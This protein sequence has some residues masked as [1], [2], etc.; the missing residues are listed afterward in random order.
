MI[1]MDLAVAMVEAEQAL[2]TEGNKIFKSVTVEKVT[3]GENGVKVASKVTETTLEDV[4][5]FSSQLWEPMH[6]R[7]QSVLEC[8]CSR[9][10]GFL[11]CYEFVSCSLRQTV[12]ATSNHE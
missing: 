5:D 6:Y 9:F 3:A 12:A 11:G 7:F 8:L 10:F 4:R 2:R 1:K